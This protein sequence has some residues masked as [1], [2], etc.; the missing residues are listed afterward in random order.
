MRPERRRSL[1]V[2]AVVA[3]LGIAT[4]TECLRLLAQLRAAGPAPRPPGPSQAVVLSPATAA[5]QLYPG[6]QAAVSLT[7]TNPGPGSVR[8]ESLSLDTTR[9][10]GGFAVDAGHSACS[11]SALS[12]TAQNNG[13]SGW[14]VPGAG[15][16]A[17]MLPNALSMGT[18]ALERVPGGDLHR[19]P[20]GGAVVRRLVTLFLVACLTTVGATAWGF[21]SAGSVAGGNGAAAAAAVNQGS[22]P[23]VTA[24][25]RTLTVSWTA[26]TLSSG[27]PVA[28]YVVKRYNATTQVLQTI[29]SSCSGTVTATTCAEA[30]VPG[31]QWVYSVTPVIGTSWQGPE[32]VKSLPVTVTG[33]MLSLATTTMRP[34]TP[35]T[36]TA[37]GF[38]S[39]ETLQYRLDNPTTGAV[40]TGSLAGTSTPTPVPGSGGGAVVVTVPAGTS[41]GAHTIYAVASPSGESAAAGIVVDGTPPPVPVLTSKPPA[42]S[43]DAASFTY[44]EAEAEATVDCQL[45]GD[46]FDA[47][48]NPTDY[49]GLAAGSHTFQAR[50]TDAVGNVSAPVSY[51]WTVDLNLPTIVVTHP[52]AAGRY[53]DAGFNAGCGTPA[54]GDLCGTADDDTA[55]LAVSVSLRRL[56][57][58]SYWNG[59][60]FSAATETFLTASGLTNWSYAIAATSLPEGDYT[61]R[62][63]VSDGPN[64]SYA[65][66][67]FT[68]DRTPPPVPT[69]TTVP[70]ATSGPSATF[71]FTTSDPTATFECR[72]DAGTWT[73]CSS[74][75]LYT[76]LAHGS[77]TVNVRAV[78]G[79]SNTSAATTTTWTVDATAP[80]VSTTFP[81][82]TRYNLAGWT[83]GCSTPTVGDLCGT[84]SDV[85]SGLAQV[86]VSIKRAGT[87]TYWDGTGFASAS[88]T[89]LTATGTTSWAYGF[90]ATSFPADGVYT[91]RWRATDAVGNSTTAGLDL[92]IDTAP[93]PA[94]VIT[95]AP[96]DP[97]GPSATFTFT[98]PEAGTTTECRLDAGSW[99]TCASPGPVQRTR[100]PA[101]T[102][103]RSEP[104]TPPAT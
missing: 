80:V 8:V 72:L 59:T 13:G 87:N 4:V 12:L 89:W 10:T 103:S 100:E 47:C 69:L 84:A 33:P 44:T 60:T 49:A 85:G 21:W 55:V 92:T 53:N 23:T 32:S 51:T 15:S 56:S 7:I 86:A 77:H 75:Q 20:E 9:G 91:L 64:L 28:G 62:A 46:A 78:D 63:R 57:T 19:L 93:P 16:S 41:D 31:G 94:P 82:A 6:G 40:L 37:S 34:G 22:T 66:R 30:K 45:D 36:G 83:A 70:P 101:P 71:A 5:A 65:S 1:V 96:T 79:A 26:S 25:G 2:V 67:T 95:Q 43:G 38:L 74:P 29:G 68:V 18:G 35:V 54:T 98:S 11:V 99:A 27:Q 3:L 24:A 88:E 73:T 90:A 17:V 14:T 50:A 61:L 52:A 76:G 102:P 58:G 81:T 48:D 39:G 42:T 104:R 97:G